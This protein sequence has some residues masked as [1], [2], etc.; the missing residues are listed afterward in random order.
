MDFNLHIPA[1]ALVGVTL[2]AL[3]ASNVRFATERFWFRPRLLA[4]M[5]LSI[6]LAGVTVYFGAQEWRRGRRDVLAG[7][8][9]QT[10]PNFSPERA[11]ALE[12]AFACEPQNFEIAY[13]IGECFRTQSLDGGADYPALG[14]KALDWYARDI[15]LNPHDGYGFLRTGMCLD[16]L[17]RHGEQTE[18]AY[19]EAEKRDPNGYYTVA[20]IG[21]HYVQTGD[22]A[23]AEEWFMRSL[24]LSPLDN[25]IAR[26][27]LSICES[28]LSG[29]ASG[30]PQLPSIY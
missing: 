1:N 28:R 3:V 4:K 13:E 27:Y 7:S 8:G 24:K 18:T 26:N 30:L 9:S 29:K 22:Y 23:A 21:W 12:K 6:A 2:L 25:D 17:G 5:T 11:A 10:T 20:N 19:R 14:Q 16:W 15:R